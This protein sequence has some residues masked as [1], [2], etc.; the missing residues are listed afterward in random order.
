MVDLKGEQIDSLPENHRVRIQIP[1]QKIKLLR[2]DNT[3]EA[4]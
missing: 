4:T 2:I 1:P 3:L